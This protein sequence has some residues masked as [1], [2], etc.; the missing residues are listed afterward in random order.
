MSSQMRA[1]LAS[2]FDEV[3]YEPI[4]NR[5]R[6]VSLVMKVSVSWCT[7]ADLGEAMEPPPRCDHGG[8]PRNS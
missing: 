7:T 4:G 3:R 6:A 1:L 2:G 8:K 5:I